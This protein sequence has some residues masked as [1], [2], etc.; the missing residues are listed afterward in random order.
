MVDQQ[1]EVRNYCIDGFILGFTLQNQV[2]K[3]RTGPL[4][5]PDVMTNF[6]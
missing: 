5:T 1:A 4:M 6:D 3:L 2:L